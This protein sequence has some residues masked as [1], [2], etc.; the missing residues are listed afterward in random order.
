MI[1]KSLHTVEAGSE[2]TFSK[3]KIFC[4]VTGSSAIRY[5]GY[6]CDTDVALGIYCH[7]NRA[8][9]TVCQ[10]KA[11]LFSLQAVKLSSCNDSVEGGLTGTGS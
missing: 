10:P 1:S 6:R 7:K 2:S 11:I 5:P 4:N 3:N 8:A 9:A